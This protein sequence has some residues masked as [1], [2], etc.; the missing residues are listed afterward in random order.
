MEIDVRTLN[1][2]IVLELHGEIDMYNSNILKET[3]LTNIHEN[4]PNVTLNF[5]DVNYIDSTG[6]GD[7]ISCYSSISGC[8]VL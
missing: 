5:K 1:D 4:K 2:N 3:I 7:L 6:I 8:S